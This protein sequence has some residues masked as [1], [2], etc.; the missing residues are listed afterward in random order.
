MSGG[1]LTTKDCNLS[2]NHPRESSIIQTKAHTAYLRNYD[3]PFEL[4]LW[5]TKCKSCQNGKL[6]RFHYVFLL[7]SSYKIIYNSIQRHRLDVI[8]DNERNIL[9]VGVAFLSSNTSCVPE[10]HCIPH[11]SNLKSCSY[12]QVLIQSQIP[13]IFYSKHKTGIKSTTTATVVAII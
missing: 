5:K 11:P 13:A 2:F 1:L 4:A 6:W 7:Y 3:S 8:I 12:W 9:R 10:T